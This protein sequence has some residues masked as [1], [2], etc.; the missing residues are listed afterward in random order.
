MPAQRRAISQGLASR[1]CV[2]GTQT[3]QDRFLPCS[4]SATLEQIKKTKN[5][6]GVEYA[7][8]KLEFPHCV[9]SRKTR[10]FQP[11]IQR[12]LTSKAQRS[13]DESTRRDTEQ[14]SAITQVDTRPNPEG[15]L[16]PRIRHRQG[17][18]TPIAANT[19]DG[20]VVTE[21]HW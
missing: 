12:P 14:E 20:R 7:G 13:E 15:E 11:P 17:N 16:F 10:L 8:T 18:E 9:R 2:Q 4:L 1:R 6:C 21:R 19:P 5:W 3:E